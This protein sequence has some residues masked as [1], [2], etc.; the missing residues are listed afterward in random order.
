MEGCYLIAL[1]QKCKSVE[2]L[3]IFNCDEKHIIFLNSTTKEVID[4][5][6]KKGHRDEPWIYSAFNYETS[7]FLTE[8]INGEKIS[9]PVENLKIDKLSKSWVEGVEGFGKGEK[10]S[11]ENCGNGSRRIYIINGFF[12]P[13]NTKLF[14]DNNRVKEFKINCYKGGLLIDTVYRKIEDTGLLQVIEFDNR[15]DKFDFIIE[16]I[17]PGKRF[18][19]TAITGIFLDALDC[20]EK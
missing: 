15:Y 12:Y 14:Y 8:E 9:Y 3:Y 5:T 17:Y 6:E 13:K 20:F 2:K 4:G 18:D 1:I 11:F 10:V 16:D 7:S 19:D